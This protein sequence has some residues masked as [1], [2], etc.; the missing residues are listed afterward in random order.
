MISINNITIITGFWYIKENTKHSI[1][2][3]YKYLKQTINRLEGHNIVFFYEDED[4]LKYIKSINNS[5]N[6]IYKKQTIHDLPTYKYSLDYL[7]SCKNQLIC[8]NNNL[9]EKGCIHFKRELIE[10]GENSY[11]QVFSIW[12][13]KILLVNN[14]IMD[15][16]FHTKYFIW[17]DASFTRFQD[18]SFN[19]IYNISDAFFYTNSESKMMTYNN[20]KIKT[21]A[22]IMCASKD[23][24][25][26]MTKLY[27]EQLSKLKD[28]LYCHDEETILSEI[29]KLH[30][31][32]FR[33]LY[34]I[35]L[36]NFNNRIEY[37][38]NNNLLNIIFIV[39]INV[40]FIYIKIP[41]N[42]ILIVLCVL[43]G[44]IHYFK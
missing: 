32:L 39:S 27:L 4:I 35:G 20:K 40:I 19:S 14:I 6:I 16:P 43:I 29:Y 33:Y 22:W 1:E 9:N 15:N 2:H 18:N 5:S 12:T 8:K 23:I 13:S 11:K 7:N 21:V 38:F 37:I 3:Y 34:N 28:T 30:P 10:S 24:W 42:K 17:V 26:K 36:E 41:I 31:Y 44:L 25:T